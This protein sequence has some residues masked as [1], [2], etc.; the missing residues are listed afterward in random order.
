MPARPYN[1]DQLLSERSKAEA[2]LENMITEM[3]EKMKGR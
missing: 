1:L 3:R 2:D